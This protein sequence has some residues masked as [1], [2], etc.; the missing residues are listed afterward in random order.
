MRNRPVFA[1]AL[2]ALLCAGSAHAQGVNRI[3]LSARSGAPRPSID[4]DRP[5]LVMQDDAG[6]VLHA[7]FDGI[8]L[9]DTAQR[10]WTTVG[11][12][13]QSRAAGRRPASAGPFADANHYTFGAVNG[14]TDFLGDFSFAAVVT[15]SGAP[16]ADAAIIADG[17]W[18]PAGWIVM[19]TSAGASWFYVSGVGVGNIALPLGVPVLLCG[20]V[21]GTRGYLKLNLAAAIQSAAIAS[22]SANPTFPFY[23]GREQQAAGAFSVGVIHEVWASTTAFSE[24]TCTTAALRMKANYGITAW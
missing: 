3:P 4:G 23:V 14:P 7:Y 11:T 16:A 13:P 17:R 1:L 10:T 18:S 9:R 19:V 5:P 22:R 6:T 12:V 2:A 20:G 15:I 8:R 24:A 21:S